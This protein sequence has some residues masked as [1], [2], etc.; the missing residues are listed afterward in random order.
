MLG[1]DDEL[2]ELGPVQKDILITKSCTVCSTFHFKQWLQNRSKNISSDL[3]KVSIT[4]LFSKVI[5]G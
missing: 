3:L 5:S 1:E 2:I 4:P